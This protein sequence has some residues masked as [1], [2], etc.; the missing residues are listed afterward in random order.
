MPS[1][2]VSDFTSQGVIKKSITQ[3]IWGGS[4]LYAPSGIAIDKLKS[5]FSR[6]AG[7]VKMHLLLREI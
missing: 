7:E 1:V 6:I 4:V 2:V 5:K 3:Y